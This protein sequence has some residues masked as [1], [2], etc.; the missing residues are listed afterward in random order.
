MEN[1]IYLGNKPYWEESMESPDKYAKWIIM[2]DGDLVWKTL[3]EDISKQEHLY[4]YFKKVYTSPN[5]II[6]KK[7]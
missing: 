7:F 2:Q 1:I 6:F 3:Y 4:K 5:I